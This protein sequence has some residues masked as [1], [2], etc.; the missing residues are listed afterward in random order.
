MWAW[1]V[2]CYYSAARLRVQVSAPLDVNRCIHLSNN[3]IQKHYKNAERAEELPSENM[4]HCDEFKE[5]LKSVACFLPLMRRGWGSFKACS[6]VWSSFFSFLLQ[7][8][9]LTFCETVAWYSIKTLR[10]RPADYYLQQGG[11]VSPGVCLFV[12]LCLALSCKNYWLGLHESFYRIQQLCCAVGRARDMADAWDSV[13]Y[14][15]M[16]NAVINALLCCQDDVEHRKVGIYQISTYSL[17]VWWLSCRAG[18]QNTRA[19]WPARGCLV[20][21]WSRC[22]ISYRIEIHCVSI[23]SSP[24]LFFLIT[25]PTVNQFE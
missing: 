21:H 23:K 1:C 10:R 20:P 14:P 18:E 16:K 13:V 2:S 19:C 3:S 22:S 4:W 12:C 17:R 15:G 24:F 9:S 5:F 11:N 7:P 25:R 8:N 6:C